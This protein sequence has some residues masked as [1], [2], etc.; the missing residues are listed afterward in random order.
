[1]NLIICPTIYIQI[2]RARSNCLDGWLS[3]ECN[4]LARHACIDLTMLLAM[5]AVIVRHCQQTARHGV[6]CNDTV[7]TPTNPAIERNKSFKMDVP[8]TEKVP[9]KIHCVWGRPIINRALSD[10]NTNPKKSKFQAR[11]LR[12]GTK[13]ILFP[14]RIQLCSL[15]QF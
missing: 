1:M 8:L 15:L 5:S 3:L 11:I 6:D 12:N 13:L 2:S 10:V 14:G 7:S 9:L 4:K